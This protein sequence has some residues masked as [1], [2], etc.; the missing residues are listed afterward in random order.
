M[1][2]RLLALLLAGALVAPQVG[3]ASESEL[4]GGGAGQATTALGFAEN[5]PL[6]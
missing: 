4:H 5:L 1:M 6:P 2:E 3:L